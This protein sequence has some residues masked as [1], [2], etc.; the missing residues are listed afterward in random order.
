MGVYYPSIVYST[1]PTTVFYQNL[2]PR[3]SIVEKV[4]S[5]VKVMKSCELHSHGVCVYIY[6]YV[7]MSVL[8]LYINLV[9]FYITNNTL[10]I[11]TFKSYRF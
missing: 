11:Y 1:Q 3:S 4:V 2:S 5:I 6:I 7:Q 10:K 9:V 8:I